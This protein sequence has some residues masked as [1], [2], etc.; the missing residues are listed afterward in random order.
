M[1][2]D[3]VVAKIL[4]QR[5]DLTKEEV[6]AR[7]EA[8]KADAQGLLSDEGAARLVAQELLVK[9]DAKAFNEIK[10]SNLVTN[11]NDVTLT[12]RVVT[13]WSLQEFRKQD[14]TS[15]K[16]L[17]LVLADKTGTIRCALWNSKAEQLSAEGELQGRMIRLAHAYTREGR[18]GIP[19][20]N[21]GERCE[22][23][24]LPA[25]LK[26][27]DYPDVSGFFKSLSEIKPS[28]GEVNVIGIVTSPPK[29]STYVRDEHEG[30][31]LKA[32]ISDGSGTIGI[33][34]WDDRAQGLTNLKKGDILQIVSGRVRTDLSD[35]PEIHL[36]GS[37]IATI[38][39]EKPPYL[40]ISQ[41][42]RCHIADLKPNKNLTLLARVLKVGEIREFTRS[43]GKTVRYGTLLAGDNT[44][45]VRIFL[46]DDKIE[47][48]D[49]LHEGD[50]LLIEDAQVKDRH[51]EVFISIGNSGTLRINPQ[52][53]DKEMP[54]CP[55]R[56][57]LAQLNDFSRPVIIEGLLTSDIELR[58]VQ[59]GNGEKIRVATLTVADGADRARLSLWRELVEAVG[60][61]DLKAGTC[62]RV[63]G[64][65]PKS[66]VAGEVV[67]TSSNLTTVKIIDKKNQGSR[68]ERRI[69]DY[70]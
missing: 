42:E 48:I 23:T 40:K 22:V 14:G 56:V 28:N 5:L 60:K 38:L 59:I 36:G 10:I 61:L 49:T 45:L 43:D 63:V 41:F 51:G 52:L 39:H 19:E 69:G 58:E 66:K 25:D 3:G 47:T 9:I 68:D 33:V 15:G 50:T 57:A 17:R 26:N 8:K 30:S 34:G 29:F 12:A 6:L 1:S 37:C 27:K 65:Q 55:K 18:L 64:A 24:V 7:I 53:D 16:L 54:M 20:L 67:M 13:Q 62:V 4:E 35:R 21:A 46:W 32:T 44:G 31:I 70:L 2:L 11:L